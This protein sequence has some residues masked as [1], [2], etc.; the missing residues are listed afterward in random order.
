[1]T[2]PANAKARVSLRYPTSCYDMRHSC[3]CPPR[4]RYSCCCC[5][6][7]GNPG[8][9]Q[10]RLDMASARQQRKSHVHVIRQWL[11]SRNCATRNSSNW[12]MNLFFAPG[13]SHVRAPGGSHG[14]AAKATQQRTSGGN[15]ENR[16]TGSIL[17]PGFAPAVSNLSHMI[18][19]PGPAVSKLRHS[20]FGVAGIV[21][22]TL[23]RKA[24]RASISGA[25]QIMAFK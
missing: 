19:K 16:V 3:A 10:S 12:W 6:L 4:Q 18:K 7:I 5:N 15:M 22:E 1:M 2:W 25:Q 14:R 17:I 21:F 9:Q 23:F 8:I 20:I 11:Y 24:I 13:L